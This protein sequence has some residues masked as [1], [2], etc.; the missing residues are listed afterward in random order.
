MTELG[1]VDR[2][3]SPE[4]ERSHSSA[5][6]SPTVEYRLNEAVYPALEEALAKARSPD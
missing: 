5:P 6:M 3:H 4:C 1:I 2:A